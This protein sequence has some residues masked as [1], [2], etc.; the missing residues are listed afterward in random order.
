VQTARILPELP[1]PQDGRTLAR[2]GPATSEQATL[3][4]DL[5]N[6]SVQG[7]VATGPRRGRAPAPEGCTTHVVF[8][9]HELIEKLIAV[10]PRPRGHLVRYHSILGSAAKNRVKAVPRFAPVEVGR[11][12]AG[13]TFSNVPSARAG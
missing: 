11:S 5:A 10:I 13:G 6:A 8:T 9:P 3:L 1:P 12:S 2:R 4:D 7:L